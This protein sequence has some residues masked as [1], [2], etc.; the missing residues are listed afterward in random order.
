MKIKDVIS[1]L[2]E[3]F[4]LYLQQEFDNCGVQCGDADQE[5]SGAIVCYE[6]SEQVLEEAIERQANLVL[7]HHPLILRR[8]LHRIIPQDRVG[9]LICKA[10]AHNM[11]L[12]SMHTNVDAAE[13]GGNDVFAVRLGLRDLSV[14]EPIGGLYRKIVF[15]APPAQADDIRSALFLA[16]GGT[17]RHYDHCSYTM[18]GQGSFRPLQ[19][20]KPFFGTVLRDETTTEERVEMIFST[21]RQR[22]II[23]ALY[24][25]HPYE[26]PAFDIIPIENPSRNAGIGRVGTLPDTMTAMDFLH[27]LKEKM[28]IEHL[29]Y[30]GD[31]SRTIR[32]VA[33]C[34]GGGASCIGSAIAAGADAFVCGDVKYHDFIDADKKLLICDIGH[35]E[36]EYFIREIIYREIAEKFTNFAV[37]ISERDVLEISFL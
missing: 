31:M 4:P 22:E 10:L 2:E 16:G 37:A 36:S 33:V 9:R 7:S 26:E 8:G 29:R 35:Y 25:T 32:R 13:G 19:D 5:I 34:G 12:Y 23:E 6:M 3:R 20:A 18:S 15:F 24:R 17:M 28:Q 11:V 14:L 27:Y 21:C 30:Y 1:V